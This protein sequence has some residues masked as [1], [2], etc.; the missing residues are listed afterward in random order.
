MVSANSMHRAEFLLDIRDLELQLTTSSRETLSVLGGVSLSVAKGETVGIVGESGSGKSVL[1]LSILGLQPK[2]MHISGG[3]I[4]FQ[5][6]HPLHRLG[7][8]ELRRIRGK[9]I[10]M[11]F[12]DPMSSLNTAFTIGSQITESLR[13]HFGCSRKEARERAHELLRVVGLPRP[14]S[15]LNEY[16][17]QLSG[18]MRQRVMIAIAISGEPHLLIADEPTTALDVTIQAQ[19]L[20]LMRQI[21]EEKGMSILLISHDLGVIADMCDRI[22][23][24]YAGQIVEEGT[25]EAVLENPKH[26]YTIGL[27]QSV[28]TPQKKYERLFSIQGTVPGLRERGPGCTFN[29]RCAHA[30]DRCF[31]ETPALYSMNG[32]QSVRCFLV[33]EEGVAVYGAG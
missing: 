5:S 8:E 23:V 15:L 28:P 26:P 3:E 29:S 11:V 31:A 25:A 21:R 13:L 10:S 19:I 16:P 30:T 33:Q 14:E 20:D 2:A 12:Q 6:K 9:E 4:W 32:Q 1:S 17:H 22:A 24:M 18:G 27:K 7:Q